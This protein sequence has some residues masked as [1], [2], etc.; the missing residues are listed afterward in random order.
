MGCVR[1]KLLALMQ[2]VN[3]YG[4]SCPLLY[5]KLDFIEKME[6]ESSKNCVFK[7]SLREIDVLVEKAHQDSEDYESLVGIKNSYSEALIYAKL[8][9]LL[10]IEKIPETSSRTPDFK[11]RYRSNDLYI[12]LKSLNMAGGNLKH[13]TVMHNAMNARI[14]AENQIAKGASF[15]FGLHLIQPYEAGSREYDADS[16]RMVIEALISKIEQNVKRAQYCLGTTI[17]L[18]DLADQLP[19]HSQPEESIQ[20]QYYDIEKGAKL[21]GELWHVAF[22]KIGDETYK[23]PKLKGN[24]CSDGKLEKTGIFNNHSYIKGMIFH[25]R[26]CF[27]GL[28]PQTKENVI[29]AEFIQYVTKVYSCSLQ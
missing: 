26:D 4:V 2:S 20:Q 18:V 19:L 10:H 29:T 5:I 9:A 11:V 28:T 25:A 21:S 15:G 23:T 12:E 27:Y 14:D 17:L 13:K 16:F 1:D 6:L 8:Q 22:D 7:K 3:T 24:A